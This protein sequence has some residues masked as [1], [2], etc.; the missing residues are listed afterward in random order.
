MSE[1][2]KQPLDPVEEERPPFVPAPVSRR[3]WAWMG[4]A[5]TLLAIL[6]IT[7]WIATSSFLTGI[8]GIML[9]PLL[10]ALCAQGINNYFLCRRGIHPGNPALL[11]GSAAVMGLLALSALI[12]GIGQT[13]SAL[14]G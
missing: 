1:L 14:G 3:I 8:T 10:G 7:Y 11:L 5:Y 9:F 2:E 12:W 13:V 4:I 6:L